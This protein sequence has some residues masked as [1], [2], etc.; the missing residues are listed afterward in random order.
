MGDSPHREGSDGN[1]AQRPRAQLTGSRSLAGSP[2]QRD[3]LFMGVSAICDTAA[4]L[5]DVDGAAVAVLAAA[6]HVRELVYATDALAQ[7]L[8]E[9]QYTLGEGPCLDAYRANRPELCARLDDPAVE[10]RWPAFTS[11]LTQIGVAAVFAFPVPGTRRPLGVLELYRRTPGELDD[12]AQRSAEVCA[13]ALRTTLEHNWL[14][15]LTHS[16]TEE[17][18]LE[19]A[20]TRAAPNPSDPFT[21]AQVH[22]A[23][24]M[25]AVQLWVSTHEALDRLRAYAF[26]QNR[27][28][29]AVA[30]DVVTRRL[31]FS[32]LDDNEPSAE[33]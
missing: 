26:A 13:A 30:A 9:L 3:P 10:G 12:V 32:E 16:V 22:V 17:A 5:T 7:H 33:S 15:H 2:T 8:D 28:T 4:R 23:A 31:S 6:Q 20:A 29:V 1:G 24:G 18:A 21:R 19:S 14:E 11:E 25:I 27:S